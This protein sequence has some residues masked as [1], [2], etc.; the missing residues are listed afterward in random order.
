VQS[1]F[2]SLGP[3]ERIGG[4]LAGL[5]GLP[6]RLCGCLLVGRATLGAVPTFVRLVV[7][8]AACFVGT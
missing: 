6:C 4:V 1:T 8:C 2:S 5:V 3:S 7:L